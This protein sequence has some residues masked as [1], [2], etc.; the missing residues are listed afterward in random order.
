MLRRFDWI[1]IQK[2]EYIIS[3]LFPECNVLNQVCLMTFISH[4]GPTPPI[5]EISIDVPKSNC[6]QG[7]M[8]PAWFFPSIVWIKDQ[9]DFSGI[10]AV[11]LPTMG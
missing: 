2:V 1:Y 3:P 8:P 11:I 5:S 4:E 10:I 9:Q 6:L 7:E